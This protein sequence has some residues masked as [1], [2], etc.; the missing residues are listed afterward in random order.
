MS[1]PEF[2]PRLLGLT[3][4]VEACAA[5]ARKFRVYYHRTD[6][7]A[8]YLVDHSIIMYLLNP[9]G[10]FVAFYGKHVLAPEL[11]AA[12]SGH[13][14]TWPWGRTPVVAAAGAAT[15]GGGAVAAPAV[16]A[17]AKT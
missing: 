10:K 16:A 1:P 7:T 11:A 13:V 9:E 14:A 3:G 12:I 4:S 17:A 5:A 15:A 2:H 6:D 8:D